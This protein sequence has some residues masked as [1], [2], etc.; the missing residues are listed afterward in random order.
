MRPSLKSQNLGELSLRRLGGRVGGEL[1][2]GGHHV[3]GGDEDEAPAEPLGLEK[4]N[5]LAGHEEVAGRVDGE[6]FLPVGEL[7]SVHRSRVGNSRVGDDNVHA[8]ICQHRLLEAASDRGLVGDVHRQPERP[9]DAVGAR[10]L[11]NHFVGAGLVQISDDDVG[12]LPC[13]EQSRSFPDPARPAG[14]HR[15]AARQ[16]F[17]GRRQGQLVEFHRPVLDFEGVFL[18]EREIPPDGRGGIQDRN[19]MAIDVVHDGGCPLILPR[20]E[21]PKAWNQDDSGERI[22]QRHSL[23][24]VRLKVAGVVVGKP[25]HRGPGRLLEMFGVPRPLD[26]HKARQALG[27]DRMVGGGGP[28]LTEL[29][30]L[31]RS[32]ELK[33]FRRIVEMKDLAPRLSHESPKGR[34]ELDRQLPAFIG[35]KS[36]NPSPSEP[37]APLRAGLN[38]LLSPADQLNGAQVCVLDRRAPGDGAVLL[39]NHGLRLGMGA[40][41]GGHLP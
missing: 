9:S 37:D 23:K 33:H 35:S 30:S 2:S 41:S 38:R 3:L 7:H 24:A 27:I 5:S 29:P 17:L 10:D 4:A 14:H 25:V 13:Q 8:A 31:S 32:D 16:L 19:R 15:D 20:C 21:H 22:E 1:F 6:A 40:E 26:G 18:G 39:Q 28:D 36:V 34:G 12:A 11:F